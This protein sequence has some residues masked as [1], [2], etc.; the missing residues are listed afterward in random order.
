MDQENCLISNSLHFVQDLVGDLKDELGGH[1]EDAVVAMMTSPADL[2]C[3]ALQ[4]ALEVQ[5]Q[6]LQAALEVQCQAAQE[7]Q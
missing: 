7:I 2:E 6:A 5:C 3:Q 1:F 4:A